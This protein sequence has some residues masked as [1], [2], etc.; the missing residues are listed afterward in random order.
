M[1]ALTA[2]LF[3]GLAATSAVRA[4]PGVLDI[5]D[6][7]Y[8]PVT[9]DPRR[10]FSEKNHTILQQLFEGLVR[11]DPE[12]RIE[13]A[14]AVSW[15][16]VDPLTVEFKLREGVRFHNGEPLDAEAVRSSLESFVDPAKGFPGV[17]LLN[18]IERI[19]AVDARTVRVRTRFP[20]GVLLHRLAGL[21]TILPPRAA[22]EM[23]EQRFATSPV[24]T[25]PFLFA[26][27]EKGRNIR[28]DANP[29]YWAGSPRFR[30][31][32]F[33]FLPVEK[34]VEGLLKG[35]IDIVTELPGTAT[36]RVMKSEHARIVKKKTFYT[37][38][39]S[40]NIST[41]PLR[42]LRVR[43]A[44]NHAIN[45]AELVRYD[46]LGNGTPLATLSMPGEIGHDPELVPYRYDPI[47]ARR[48]LAEAGYP[49][50]VTLKGV[51]KAQGERTL[52]IVSPQLKRVGIRLETQLTTDATVIQD[53]QSKHWDFTFGGCPDP[54]AHSFFI[55][56]IFLSSVSPYSLLHYPEYDS[57]LRRMVETLEPAEQHR[58]GMLLDRFMQQEALSIFTY[59]RIKTYGVAKN[60]EFVPAVTGM[61]YLHLSYPHEK[62]PEAGP[63]R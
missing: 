47:K 43:Q 21:V 31:I 26:G 37:V 58:A 39:G 17:G 6:D 13:P 41:G 16:R 4:E 53:I 34:Q 51:V 46:L 30:R 23:G 29:S 56:S 33:H 10:E 49:N 12:G 1:T 19:E 44:L 18:S 60:V 11:F 25:G 48:L 9:L 2:A 42:D 36:L 38:G 50:G 20:D 27:W 61:P 45:R 8:E 35:E 54:L 14:L 40:L 63:V 57:L 62:K 3:L 59:Q 28:L 24:G 32:V 15:S 22:A 52:R 5:C 7:E 55:Q